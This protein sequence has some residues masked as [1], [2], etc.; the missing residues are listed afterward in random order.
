MVFSLFTNFLTFYD[1]VET[2][3]GDTIYVKL[4]HWFRQLSDVTPGLVCQLQTVLLSN[5]LNPNFSFIVCVEYDIPHKEFHT[6]KNFQ[7]K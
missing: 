6:R 3:T 2:Y 7:E 1:E 5:S 4:G